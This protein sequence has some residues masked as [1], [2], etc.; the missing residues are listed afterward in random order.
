[1]V[2]KDRAIFLI[3]FDI[4]TLA[5]YVF[6][7]QYLFHLT[8]TNIIDNLFLKA[9]VDM[10]KLMK[11]EIK[12]FI[13]QFT[14]QLIKRIKEDDLGG[15]AAQTTYYLFLSI[16]PFLIFLI[17]LLGFTP[18]DETTVYTSLNTILPNETARLLTNIIKEVLNNGSLTFLSLGMISALWSTSKGVKSLI[19]GI[20]RAY[21]VKEMR[22]FIH[23]QL[24]T[25]VTTFTIPSLIFTNFMLLVLGDIL[26]TKFFTLVG[27]DGT[28]L[29]SW[30]LVRL[31]L[32]IILMVVFFILFY[33]YAPCRQLKIKNVI[34]GALFTSIMWILISLLFSYY[35]K[36]FGNYTKLYGSVGSIIVL[37]LWLNMCSLIVYIGGEINATFAYFSK[38]HKVS[39]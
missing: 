16:F 15:L 23:V 20:N 33:K 8:S 3:I 24:I 26:A 17:S 34:G 19:K 22:S 32:P 37:L 7:Y 36:N 4:I 5:L 13:K 28:Y 14:K 18:L 21:D 31:L 6:I 35:V 38:S 30:T 2:F 25:L 12:Q 9:G 11:N 10:N 27:I 39:S 29:T 1:M